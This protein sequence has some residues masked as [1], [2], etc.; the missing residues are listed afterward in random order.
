M[1]L[2]ININDLITGQTVEWDR[3]EF[4]EG[5]NPEAVLHTICAFANDINNWGGGYIIIGIE[6]KDGMPVLPPKGLDR[7]QLDKIQKEIIQITHY[8][9]PVYSPVSQPVL[10]HGKQILIVWVPGGGIRPY[11]ASSALSAKG[12]IK[13]YYIR[14]GSATIVARHADVKQLMELAATIPFDDR[15]NHSAS[16]TDLD[17]GLVREFLQDIKSG[18]FE[19]SAFMPFNELCRQMR[20]VSG[21]EEYLKPVNAGLLFFNKNPDTFFRGAFTEIVQFIDD[22]GTS[23]SEKK[24]TGPIHHQ[25]KVALDFIKT[26]IIEER[27]IKVRGKEKALRFFSYPFGAVEEALV[28]AYYHRSYEHQNSIEINIHPDRIEILSFP[29][30]LPPVNNETLKEKRVVSRDYRNRR[31]GDFLKELDLAEGRATGLPKIYREM[32]RNESPSPIFITDKEKTSFSVNITCSQLFIG[33]DE[34]EFSLS[35]TEFSIITICAGRASSK[36]EIAS[37]LKLSSQSGTLKRL[38]PKL[39]VEG[40]LAYTIPDKPNSSAQK[41]KAMRRAID[42]INRSSESI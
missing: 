1:A 40:F 24:I 12:S 10:Y 32:E 36:S 8:I 20:I 9:D 34:D 14:R 2:P 42:Y 25:I 30:P 33:A 27:V 29:G 6:E 37:V 16:L 41:Y 39:V 21:P 4:K 35:G 28:N 19:H 7:A 18:L 23:F 15:I 26:N 5:W 22:T 31:I 3:I 38:L 11:K 13:Q 17:L